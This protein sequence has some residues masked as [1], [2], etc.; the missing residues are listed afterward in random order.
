MRLQCDWV[1][2]VHAARLGS[3]SCFSFLWVDPTYGAQTLSG[4]QDLLDS[5]KYLAMSVTAPFTAVFLT[6][7][8]EVEAVLPRLP[9]HVLEQVRDVEIVP[10]FEEVPS[11]FVKKAVKILS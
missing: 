6:T 1:I 11:H 5:C 2:Y 8:L 3:A 7:T 10:Q 9:G 4:R